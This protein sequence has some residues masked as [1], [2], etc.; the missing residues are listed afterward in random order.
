MP[1]L[2]KRPAPCLLEECKSARLAR[3]RYFAN[4]ANITSDGLFDHCNQEKPWQNVSGSYVDGMGGD[5][6]WQW[7]DRL[8]SGQTLMTG[9]SIHYGSADATCLITIMSGLSTRLNEEIATLQILDCMKSIE[10]YRIRYN[11][12]KTG[13]EPTLCWAYCHIAARPIQPRLRSLPRPPL[14]RGTNQGT[15]LFYRD[16]RLNGETS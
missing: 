11:F 1:L 13:F 10:V 4:W 7:G 5:A 14:Y 2:A 6:F 3:Y 12:P 8:S 15:F 9:T 16:T